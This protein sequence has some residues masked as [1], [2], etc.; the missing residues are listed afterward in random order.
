MQLCKSHM[1]LK[2]HAEW[3][4]KGIS[5]VRKWTGVYPPSTSKHFQKRSCLGTILWIHYY[6]TQFSQ[7]I[8]ILLFSMCTIWTLMFISLLKCTLLLVSMFQLG[9]TKCAD[10]M[11]GTPGRIKGISGGEM[12]R[13]SFASEVKVY[14]YTVN[15]VI[16]AGGKFCEM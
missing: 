14:G 6:Q 7:S 4:R 13:L 12:K 10:T 5:F 9:L 11:I 16:F 1:L 15:V 8:H 2:V 3:F